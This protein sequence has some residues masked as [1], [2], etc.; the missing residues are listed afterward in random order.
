[1]TKSFFSSPTPATRPEFL[2]DDRRLQIGIDP[3]AVKT[4]GIY[5][6]YSTAVEGQEGHSRGLIPGEKFFETP[7]RTW[8]IR[9][10]FAGE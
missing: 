3:E 8:M 2:T 4:K 10:Y 5:F 7:D 9:A 6:H 1:M